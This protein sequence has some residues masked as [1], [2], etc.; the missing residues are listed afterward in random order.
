M[1]QLRV[2][3]T[4]LHLWGHTVC[5]AFLC[6]SK[7]QMLEFLSGKLPMGHF[8]NFGKCRKTTHT[9]PPQI[10]HSYQLRNISPMLN[11]VLTKNCGMNQTIWDWL[12]VIHPHIACCGQSVQWFGIY[13]KLEAPTDVIKNWHHHWTLPLVWVI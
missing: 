8:T 6:F 10:Y 4:S 1:T 13:V 12:P 9:C 7:Q 2:F 5:Y 11:G 3:T